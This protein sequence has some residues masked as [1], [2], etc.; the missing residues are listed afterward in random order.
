MRGLYVGRFQPF[1]R[2]HEMVVDNIA[3]DEDVEEVVVAIGSAQMSHSLR[4]PFTA[5][6]RVSM[7]TKTL[8]DRD[9]T[10]YAIPIEDLNRNAVWT[11]HV[12]SMCPPFG[13][14]YSNNPLIVRL[15]E[16]EGAELRRSPMYERERFSG[17]EIR[18]R[19]LEGGDWRSLVPDAVEDVVDEVEGVQRL[20]DLDGDDQ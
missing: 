13:V 8:E 12:R 19:M 15:F 18:R 3:E 5:G 9:T 11:T 4:N 10:V 6:E 16:E 2:G 14:V 1:H 7:I 17:S 20:R